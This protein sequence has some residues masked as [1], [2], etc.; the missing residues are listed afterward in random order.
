MDIN[1]SLSPLNENQLRFSGNL[2]NFTNLHGHP[3]R[4]QAQILH[5]VNTFLL[6]YTADSSPTFF[7]LTVA[8]NRPVDDPIRRSLRT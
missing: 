4:F 1:F 6:F 2:E 3:A 7:L 5:I 8:M